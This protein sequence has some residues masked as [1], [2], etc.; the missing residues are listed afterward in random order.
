MKKAGRLEGWKA[1]RLEGWRTEKERRGT[2]RQRG[3][4]TND[5]ERRWK[6]DDGK[7]EDR[8]QTTEDGRRKIDGGK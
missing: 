6:I 5:G 4:K 2:G 3:K 7:Q 8:K 1:G